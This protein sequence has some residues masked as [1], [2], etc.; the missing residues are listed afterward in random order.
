MQSD[1]SGAQYLVQGG[2]PWGEQAREAI[3]LLIEVIAAKEYSRVEN[4]PALGCEQPATMAAERRVA[5]GGGC[6]V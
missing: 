6:L 1:F 2:D 3:C 5:S 4:T